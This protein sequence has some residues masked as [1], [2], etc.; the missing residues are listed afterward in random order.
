MQNWSLLSPNCSTFILNHLSAAVENRKCFLNTRFTVNECGIIFLYTMV[1]IIE[2]RDVID[3]LELVSDA[4][5]IF[6]EFWGRITFSR[7]REL[8]CHR[9]QVSIFDFYWFFFLFLISKLKKE[10]IF[11]KK[12][13]KM[14]KWPTKAFIFG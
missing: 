7:H 3:W 14:R 12:L 8:V 6:S 1:K 9:I 5:Q 2:L 4:F 11:G 13:I 10:K